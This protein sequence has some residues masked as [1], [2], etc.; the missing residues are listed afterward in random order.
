VKF[1]P[2]VFPKIPS[3][4]REA[5][6]LHHVRT[7]VCLEKIDGANTRVSASRAGELVFGGRT[8]LEGDPGFCQPELRT[9]FT[10]AR[11][12]VQWA[13]EAQDDITLYGETCGRGI[14]AQG[15]VY[16]PRA[17]F[18]LFAA[19][20]GAVWLSHS[21]PTE[22]TTDD[23]PPRLLPSLVDV[24]ERLALP[25]APCLY[26]G[27]PEAT[28]FDALLERA[29]VHG[30]RTRAGGHVPDTTHEGVV[31][32]SDP[33]LLDGAGR[34]L[35]AK[36]KHPR[37]REAGDASAGG[38]ESVAAFAGRVVLPERVAHA[39]Q[40]LRESGRWRDDAGERVELL[41]RRVVQDVAREEPAYH[42]Q[43]ARHGKAAVRAAL[44]AAA[45]E[46]IAREGM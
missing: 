32:W 46:V 23:G 16:G 24:A 14:Q 29:S 10:A 21:Y 34:L 13:A 20:V 26:R 12:L 28:A 17:H 37:R 22:L 6:T 45:R 11:A 31:I 15:F 39:A 41:V 7:V 30:E 40:H 18:V 38:D 2:E 27:V 19:R 3:Y 8:L 25:L 44:E 9:A 43:L 42:A 1:I 36:H 5:D 35:V 33:L 4:R